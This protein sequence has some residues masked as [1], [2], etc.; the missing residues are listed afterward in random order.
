[1]ASR[2][3]RK[4]RIGAALLSSYITSQILLRDVLPSLAKEAEALLMKA[5]EP[6]LSAQVGDL[7]IVERCRC[8]SDFC[9]SFYTQ[10][11]PIGSY[12]PGHSNIALEP[13]KGMLVLDIVSGQIMQIEVLY[14]DEI[15]KVIRAILP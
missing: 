5:N 12:G 15:R 7:K 4:K 2:N 3:A 6:E 14:R 1:M 9:A 10:P 8:E 11:K 13:E